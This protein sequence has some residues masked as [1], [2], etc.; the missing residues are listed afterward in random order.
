M[1]S[2]LNTQIVGGF[3]KLL[4]SQPFPSFV[5]YADVA[6][7]DVESLFTLGFSFLD[8]IAPAYKCISRESET[9]NEVIVQSNEMPRC[10]KDRHCLEK[11][12]A[13]NIEDTEFV[14]IYDCGNLKLEFKKM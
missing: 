13:K 12:N 9:L 8:A 3:A 14:Q 2:K 5:F 7:I 10:F 11:T 6:K 4:S 1:C